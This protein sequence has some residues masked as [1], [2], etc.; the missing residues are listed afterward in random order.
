MSRILLVSLFCWVLIGCSTQDDPET[1]HAVFMLDLA[2]EYPSNWSNGAESGYIWFYSSIIR[3]DFGTFFLISNYDAYDDSTV[4]Q[5]IRRVYDANEDVIE[6]E[7]PNNG[8]RVLR[9]DGEPIEVDP[10]EANLL[11]VDPE[12]ELYSSPDG[13]YIYS[14]YLSEDHTIVARVPIVP[15]IELR[16]QAF[17]SM[18][19]SAHTLSDKMNVFSFVGGMTSLVY[20]RDWELRLNN[21]VS[22]PVWRSEQYSVS[23]S[24]DIQQ[25]II[26]AQ[27]SLAPDTSYDKFMAFM[28]DR[29]ATDIDSETVTYTQ[30]HDTRI[31]IMPEDNR[32]RVYFGIEAGIWF[33]V[34]FVRADGSS[35]QETDEVQLWQLVDSILLNQR[36]SYYDP[37]E[38]VIP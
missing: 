31:A 16:E 12:S 3:D 34:W 37:I 18:L 36:E 4:E 8:I 6:L 30:R 38:L 22:L 24:I 23:I 13:Y 1:I 27:E 29:Y 2:I 11:N 7:S 14:A 20:P 25:G 9:V 17:L 15:E 5:S 26:D 28:L 33:W 10:R 19:D 35:I 21:G 32:I